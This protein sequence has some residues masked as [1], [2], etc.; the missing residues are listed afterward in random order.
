MKIEHRSAKTKTFLTS[1][2]TQV[3]AVESSAVPELL[4][5]R[6]LYIGENLCKNCCHAA[7]E[8]PPDD[9]RSTGST[10]QQIPG[11]CAQRGVVFREFP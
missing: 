7:G 10:V 6:N 3:V 11:Q 2:K 5:R 8:R 9:L 4:P 1:L